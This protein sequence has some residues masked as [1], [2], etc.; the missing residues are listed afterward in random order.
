MKNQR[1]IGFL[2]SKVHQLGGRVFARMLKE[3]GIKNLNPAQGR[4]MFVLWRTDGIAINELARLT[5]LG[6]STLTSML[7]RLEKA[8]FL[9]RVLSPDDRRK[10]IILRTEKDK[11]LEKEYV[12]VSQSMAAVYLKGFSG[13]E[14]DN[15]K[16]YLGRIYDNLAAG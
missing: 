5:A 7:D 2:V 16:D 3:H 4:I 9:K 14:L 12:K 1:Q 13:K 10:I 6:K 15:L 8:G 11:T